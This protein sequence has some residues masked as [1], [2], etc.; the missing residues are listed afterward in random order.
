MKREVWIDVLK[1]IAILAVVLDHAFYIFYQYRN[2]YIWQH[3]FFSITWF[4]FLAAVTNTKSLRLKNWR[5]PGSYFRFWYRRAI[6]TVVPYVVISVFI[7]LF[8]NFPKVNTSLL[9]SEL[10]NFSVQPTYYFINLLLQLYFVFPF[11]YSIIK[12]TKRSWQRLIIG[13]L[14]FIA[15]FYVFLAVNNLP[16]PF[17]SLG[18]LFGGNYFFVFVLGILYARSIVKIDLLIFVISTLTFLIYESAINTVKI[19]FLR[20]V[21]IH[22]I[23]WS[24]ALFLILKRLL[25]GRA[26]AVTAVL[27]F[28]GRYSLFIY[29]LHYFIIGLGAKIQPMNLWTAAVVVIVSVVFSAM[30]G[31]FYSLTT[32]VLLP[33][34]LPRQVPTPQ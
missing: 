20:D 10:V 25:S 30:T 27:S 23:V 29:L 7:F 18:V 11:L 19:F 2:Y 32:R 12:M 4:V 26:N 1:G 22:L 34:V 9:V 16:W 17:Y 13:I 14:A 6:S 28:L 24:M 31:Y 21:S 15:A 3:T 5:F 33:R 8:Y